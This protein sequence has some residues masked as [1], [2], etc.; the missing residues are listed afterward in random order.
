VLPAPGLGL[1]QL[2]DVRRARAVALG[3]LGPELV[4]DGLDLLAD[5]RDAGLLQG[6]RLDGLLQLADLQLVEAGQGGVGDEPL[7]PAPVLVGARTAA[8]PAGRP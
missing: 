7:D 3:Q 6:E 8:A 4:Q 1:E 5:G 2:A